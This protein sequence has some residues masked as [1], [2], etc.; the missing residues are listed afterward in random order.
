MTTADLLRE[1]DD[2][3]RTL[4]GHSI[5]NHNLTE[6][7]YQRW[8]DRLTSEDTGKLLRDCYHLRQEI[9]NADAH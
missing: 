2:L 5:C 7:D 9:L 8:A 6:E 3:Q 1:R 4:D